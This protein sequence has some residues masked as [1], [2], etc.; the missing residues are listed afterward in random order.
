MQLVLNMPVLTNQGCEVC[1]TSSQ[2]GQ[3]EAIG[4]GDLGAAVCR[5]DRFNCN[6]RSDAGPLLQL[7]NA[8]QV[9]QNPQASSNPPAMSD[10]KGIEEGVLIAQAEVVLD[11]VMKVAA[12]DAVG[13]F[14]IA[15][16]S[17]SGA[18]S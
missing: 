17:E 8:A 5:P 18:G 4:A 6:D 7:S 16:G 3:V 12:D 15:P 1:C 14:V 2:T 10:V 9:A 13:P 11:V